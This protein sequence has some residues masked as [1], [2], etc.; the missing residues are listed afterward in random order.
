MKA[1]DIL[2]ILQIT[3]HTLTKYVKSGKIKYSVKEN[4]QV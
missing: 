4:G 2:Q 1:N 3:R